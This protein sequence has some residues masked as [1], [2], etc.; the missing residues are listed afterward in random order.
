MYL[1]PEQACEIA[2]VHKGTLDRWRERGYVK[3][4]K[5]GTGRYRYSK[6]SLLAFL[7]IT[8]L[9]APELTPEQEVQRDR[10]RVRADKKRLGLR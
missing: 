9:P 2:N 5:S 7:G 1:T 6:E 10:E 3:A 8:H 4:V